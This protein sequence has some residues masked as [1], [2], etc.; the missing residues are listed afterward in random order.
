MSNEI[1]ERM[2]ELRLR[3]EKRKAR[4]AA[5]EIEAVACNPFVERSLETFR[6]ER[7]EDLLESMKLISR[8]P[9][10]TVVK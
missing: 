4:I 7:N 8:M 5:L 6:D 2:E 10:E 1:Y 9:R 3:H